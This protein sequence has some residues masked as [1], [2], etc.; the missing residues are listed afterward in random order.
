[1]GPNRDVQ[2]SGLQ[3]WIQL[4]KLYVYSTFHPVNLTIHKFKKK[5]GK[6]KRI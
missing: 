2:Q 6:V 1:M 5:K 3:I 4:E